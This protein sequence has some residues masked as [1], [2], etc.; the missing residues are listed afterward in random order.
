MPKHTT[1]DPALRASDI[2]NREAEEVWRRTGKL[3]R[4]EQDNEANLQ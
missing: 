1:K 4:V 2:A 3:R